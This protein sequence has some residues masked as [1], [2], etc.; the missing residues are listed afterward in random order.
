MKTL[1][2]GDKVGEMDAVTYFMWLSESLCSFYELKTIQTSVK[3]R[4]YQTDDRAVIVNLVNELQRQGYEITANMKEQKRLQLGMRFFSRTM[5]KK[6][7]IAVEIIKGEVFT[8]QTGL[9]TVSKKVDEPDWTG[10]EHIGL[11][12]FLANQ[13]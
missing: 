1:L 10:Q 2:N 13:L 12:T 4:V 11:M 9:M 5:R 8:I 3:G 6:F 7:T